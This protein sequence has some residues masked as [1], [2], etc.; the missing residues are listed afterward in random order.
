MNI[1]NYLY[2]KNLKKNTIFNKNII[3]SMQ[4]HLTQLENTIVIKQYDPKNEE[5]DEN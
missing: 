3:N 1:I 5:K 2:K 4:E